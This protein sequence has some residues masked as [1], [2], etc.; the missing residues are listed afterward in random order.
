[1]RTPLQIVADHYAASARHD[2]D[3]ML[4]D[5]APD[6]Q[7]V[8]MA[9]APTAGTFVGREQIIEHVFKPIGA[10]WDDFGFELQ[11]LVDGGDTIVALGH[12]SGTYRPSGKP[13]RARV[14]HV[15]QVQGGQVRRFEQFA[16]TVLLVRAMQR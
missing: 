16:D 15:W 9:G 7:W 8:E 4:A 12:Y 5:L 1:M 11:R 14:A 3:G 6:V 2:L 10:E 13:M